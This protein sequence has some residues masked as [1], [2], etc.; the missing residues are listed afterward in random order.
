MAEQ[1]IVVITGATSGIGQ[2]AAIEFAKQGFHLVL[3]ARSNA[4]AKEAE[5][6]IKTATPDAP[7]DF[8]FR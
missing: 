1:S 3:T 2:L 7:I 6:L 5:E 4:K 8:F